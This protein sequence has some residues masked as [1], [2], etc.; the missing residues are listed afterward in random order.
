MPE[1]A[2]GGVLLDV[3]GNLGYD[4]AG[5]V[6]ARIAIT[7]RGRRDLAGSSAALR[8]SVRSTEAIAVVGGT[9]AAHLSPPIAD[10]SRL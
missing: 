2:S 10:R 9:V 1:E 3:V 8:V 6:A 7:V 4:L 5:D